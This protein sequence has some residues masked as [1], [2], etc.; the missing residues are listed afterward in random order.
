MASVTSASTARTGI[1]ALTVKRMLARRTQA[2][3]LSL[4]TSISLV[5]HAPYRSMSAF[6]AMANSV[7]TRALAS[8][9]TDTNV[10][11]ATI[12]ISAPAARLFLVLLTIALIL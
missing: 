2:T 5:F 3:P 8:L 10:P 9:V 1:I 12:R 11:S 6:T 7:K 4:S